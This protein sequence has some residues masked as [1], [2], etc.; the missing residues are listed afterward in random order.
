MSKQGQKFGL[1][2]EFFGIIVIILFKKIIGKKF[3]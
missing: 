1:K 3:G 2:M